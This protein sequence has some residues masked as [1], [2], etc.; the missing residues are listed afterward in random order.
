MSP[1]LSLGRQFAI[2]AHSRAIDS[3]ADLEELRQVAKS[4]LHAWQLQASFSEDYAAQLMGLQPS[5]F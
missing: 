2:E 3:C 1:S 4:L 5:G